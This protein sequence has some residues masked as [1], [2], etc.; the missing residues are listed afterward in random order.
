MVKMRKIALFLWTLTLMFYL[1]GPA[2]TLP[3]VDKVESG[4][5]KFENPN[6]ATMNITAPDKSVINF[7]SF[8]VAPNEAVNFIQPSSSASV[9][10]RVTGP[11]ASEINGS[12]SANGMLVLVN[13]NG[14]HF[15]PSSNVQVNTLIAST[16]DINTNNFIKSNYIFERNAYTPYGYISNEGMI[17]TN[18]V[19]L[20]ASAVSNSGIIQAKAGTVH[21]ASG[22]KVAV[23]IDKRG[24][25]R[26]EI[27]ERTSGKVCDFNG[28]TVKD[29]VA[30]S[31]RIEA[32][33]VY[34]TAKTASDIFKNAVNQTGVVKATGLAQEGSVIKIM[35]DSNIQVS[36]NMDAG[37][38]EISASTGDTAYISS[39]LETKGNTLIEADNDICHR[40]HNNGLGRSRPQGG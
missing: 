29:A 23:A 10:G 36:G 40:G 5:V 16:L 35:A 32:A 39:K 6:Q 34:M 24:L 37:S 26:V 14:I 30:N 18:N 22:D 31:G 3:E 8:N 1:T 28:V 25:I 27:T 33:E 12:L 11:G 7:R 19:A 9:L 2:W 4:D 20:M 17:S 38:G 13:P 21:V 15:G